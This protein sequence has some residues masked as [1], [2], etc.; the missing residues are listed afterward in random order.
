MQVPIILVNDE[1]I[2]GFELPF[3]WTGG[4]SL[5]S[6]SFVESV[7]AHFGMLNREI[8]IGEKT[9]FVAGTDWSQTYI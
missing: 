6:I 9:F 3:R 8:Y 2:I 4:V 5:D 7:V 1:D